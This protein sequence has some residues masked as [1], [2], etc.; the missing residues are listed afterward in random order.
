M[1]LG[2]ESWRLKTKIMRRCVKAKQAMIDKHDCYITKRLLAKFFRLGCSFNLSGCEKEMLQKVDTEIKR[3]KFLH[4]INSIKHQF[5]NDCIPDIYEI[6]RPGTHKIDI[7]TKKRQKKTNY[8]LCDVCLVPTL[9]RNISNISK[10]I[11]IKA[12]TSNPKFQL[13]CTPCINDLGLIPLTREGN[14]K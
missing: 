13:I 6:I 11:A 14:Q 4:M 5:P 10:Y 12:F 1:S 2:S 7:I 3:Q 9:I 8:E